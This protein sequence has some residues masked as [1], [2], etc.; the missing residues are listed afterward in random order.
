LLYLWP[1]LRQRVSALSGRHTLYVFEGSGD[2]RRRF[3]TEVRGAAIDIREDWVETLRGEPAA[4]HAWLVEQLRQL[5]SVVDLPPELRLAERL[6][7]SRGGRLVGRRL[8]SN[9]L[10][11]VIGSG[12]FG[13]IY[14]AR[15]DAGE[16]VAVKV[17]ES[18]RDPG[19]VHRFRREFAK[20][21]EAEQ[22]PAVVRVYE[23]GVT[24]VE[25]R[26]YPWYS[27]EFAPGGDLSGRM[28]ERHATLDKA[29]P[30]EIP[31]MREQVLREFQ[32]VAEGVAHLHRLDIIHRDVKP[33]NVLITAEGELRLS[34]FGLVKMADTSGSAPSCGPPTSTG[35]VVGTP[36]YMAPEQRGGEVGKTADVYS[37][38]VLLAELALGEIPEPDPFA[39][40]GSTLHRCVALGRLPDVWRRLIL[41]CTDVKPDV[42]PPNAGA[43]QEE[44]RKLL[45]KRQGGGVMPAGAENERIPR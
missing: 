13:T 27:M 17:I 35:A 14:A 6:A 23:E 5:P 38:G 31:A 9:R 26:D 41:S 4:D 30:W 43:F 11:A 2:K 12:G 29:I 28:A 15:T 20:L 42:R 36:R 45:Q 37:L 3:L 24:V 33:A 7:P 1:F 44:L 10:L 34:D 40:A 39:Q 16:R 25:G 19:Q 8:G 22:S 32:E 18:A 21:R